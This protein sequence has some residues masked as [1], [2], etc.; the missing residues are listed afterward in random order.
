MRLFLAKSQR[1]P[2][3]RSAWWC[4][5]STANE[6]PPQIPCYQGNL[7]G[8]LPFLG[9]F[10]QLTGR[11]ASDVNDLLLNSLSRA[12]GNSQYIS[13]ILPRRAGNAGCDAVSRVIMVAFGSAAGWAS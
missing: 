7:E 5:Q 9:Q 12:A 2:N 8:I 3:R 13:G 10:H 11:S 6:S 4:R 1:P